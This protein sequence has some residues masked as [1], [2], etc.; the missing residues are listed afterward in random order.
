MWMDWTGSQRNLWA[1]TAPGRAFGFGFGV[2]EFD[3]GLGLGSGPG[4]LVVAVVFM[5]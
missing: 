3:F 2:C 5:R 4:F 1:Q